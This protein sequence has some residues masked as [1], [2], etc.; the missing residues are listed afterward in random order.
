MEN[1]SEND[2]LVDKIMDRMIEVIGDNSSIKRLRRSHI[3][4]AIIGA[5]GFS[6]FIDGVLKLFNNFPSW[7]SLVLG[8]FLMLITGL[9]LKNL[10]R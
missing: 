2:E 5:V 4:S 3:L 1:K 7:A 10:Y 8:L 9:L 6:L